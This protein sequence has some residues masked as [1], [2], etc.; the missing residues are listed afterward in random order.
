MDRGKFEQ[1]KEK[2]ITLEDVKR[3][4]EEEKEFYKSVVTGEKHSLD[5]GL[6]EWAGQ[7]YKE[8]VGFK[9]EK[10]REIPGIIKKLEDKNYEECLVYLEIILSGGSA[11]QGNTNTLDLINHREYGPDFPKERKKDIESKE[12]QERK[13]YLRELADVL[14]SEV[15]G[16]ELEEKPLMKSNE[17]LNIL[18]LVARRTSKELPQLQK[19]LRAGNYKEILEFLD[20]RISKKCLQE[21][22]RLNLEQRSGEKDKILVKR[23]IKSHQEKLFKWRRC[24]RF[25]L[26]LQKEKK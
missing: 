14:T 13:N 1:K 2:E 4:F 26:N 18:E 5:I 20:N 22:H 7:R 15:Y 10:G 24:R 21:L 23:E 6:R 19:E 25:F 3:Y 9:D 17:I 8:L 12:Y 11:A 16:S